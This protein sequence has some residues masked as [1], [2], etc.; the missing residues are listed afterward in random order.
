MDTGEDTLY[1]G[2]QLDRFSNEVA[3]SAMNSSKDESGGVV[4]DLS[5]LEPGGKK[6][7]KDEYSKERSVPAG[8]VSI[9]PVSGP[10]ASGRH[11]RP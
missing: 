6:A 9:P 11:G 2:Q 7:V 1:K 5:T 10:P 3:E 4:A 8:P